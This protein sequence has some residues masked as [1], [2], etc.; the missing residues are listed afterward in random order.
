VIKL[1]DRSVTAAIVD[2]A[3]PGFAEKPQADGY[4]KLRENRQSYPA[5]KIEALLIGFS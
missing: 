5:M 1:P 3:R 4:V 2:L